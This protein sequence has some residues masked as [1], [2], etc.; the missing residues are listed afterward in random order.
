MIIFVFR[1]LHICLRELLHTASMS[2]S[3]VTHTTI[4]N[5]DTNGTTTTTNGNSDRVL[6]QVPKSRIPMALKASESRPIVRQAPLAPKQ[7]P[8][9]KNRFCG[10]ICTPH[11]MT[12][13]NCTRLSSHT[14]C[15]ASGEPACHMRC[16]AGELRVRPPTLNRHSAK[17]LHRLRPPT[18]NW[19]PTLNRHSAKCRHRLRLRRQG[20]KNRC[21]SH[22]IAA[23]SEI[24]ARRQGE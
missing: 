15:C 19:P 7:R 13:T 6:M 1:T 10:S 11:P 23:V 3:E 12:T 24:P 9:V 8:T 22:C 21:Q 18:S 20:K 5:G 14:D 2:V 4:N 17:C 16:N